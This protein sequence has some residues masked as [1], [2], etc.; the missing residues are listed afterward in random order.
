M[1]GPI[2]DRWGLMQV[3]E[4]SSGQSSRVLHVTKAKVEQA[5]L[6]EAGQ[7]FTQAQLTP[8]LQLPL[9]AEFREVGVKRPAF[10]AVLNGTYVPPPGCTPASIKLLEILH[11]LPNILDINLGGGGIYSGLA[12]S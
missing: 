12:K 8:F 4:L 11:W 5:C 2:K 1:L 10:W 7:C 6:E 3:M 9:L